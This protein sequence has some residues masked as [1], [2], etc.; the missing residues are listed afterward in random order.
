MARSQP[1][2]MHASAVAAPSPVARQSR[3]TH[4]PP[5]HL[6]FRPGA[7]CAA[8]DISWC[9]RPLTVYEAQLAWCKREIL[10]RAHNATLLLL[11][12]VGRCCRR[13]CCRCRHGAGAAVASA[14]LLLLL[15]CRVAHHC[16]L[17][18]DA[19]PRLLELGSVT[20]EGLSKASC[21]G[22]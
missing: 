6:A 15:L 8:E 19:A 7:G 10:G 2:C 9:L 17:H 3:P 4:P 1:A 21:T 22:N 13:S 18:S 20:G 14:L 12:L 11:L 5:T 16:R